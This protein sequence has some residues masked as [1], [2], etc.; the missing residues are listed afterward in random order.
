[1]VVAERLVA[2]GDPQF[3]QVAIFGRPAG[4]G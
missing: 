1:M 3:A 2:V 4:R